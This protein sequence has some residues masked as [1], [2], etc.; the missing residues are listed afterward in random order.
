[1]VAASSK[2]A[3]DR[4]GV[5]LVSE[6]DAAE[7]RRLS[8]AGLVHVE[9]ASSCV[10]AVEARA[11]RIGPAEG[12]GPGGPREV[13][14]A[15]RRAARGEQ[16]VPIRSLSF[17]PKSR[18]AHHVLPLKPTKQRARIQMIAAQ[19]ARQSEE[20]QRPFGSNLVA[21]VRRSKPEIVNIFFAFVCVLL[22]YQIHGMRARIRKLLAEREE[23]DAEVDR[24]RGILASMTE[25]TEGTG[26]GG[27]DGATFSARVAQRCAEVVRG[28]FEESERR[29]GY[30]WILGKK[31]A[32]GDALEL[33][34]LSDRLQ[35][36]ILA[37]IKSVVGNA[38]FTPE[39][40]KERRVEALKSANNEST[41]QLPGDDSQLSGSTGRKDN[42]MG[43][44]MQILEEVHNK[45]LTDEKVATSDED[46]DN[47]ST[48][49]R[50]TRY[51]I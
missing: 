30:S 41:H 10:C 2:A 38:A 21:F 26:E 9:T 23:G 40:L 1:M 4:R 49:V 51:A 27:G 36:V 48:K 20:L 16:R 44:L 25:S 19:K 29:V 5:A 12:Q 42:Q 8:K 6:I 32:G 34:K 39:E 28:V 45:D 35:P 50:R 31:L 37:D 14:T 47:A 17:W 18:W 33:E 3:A 11:R 46:N 13:P 22:A 7:L 43:D 24:L 15:P